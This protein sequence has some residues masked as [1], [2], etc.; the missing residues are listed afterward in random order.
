MVIKVVIKSLV[1]RD[2]MQS[3]YSGQRDDLYPKAGGAR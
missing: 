2:H 1:S 3:G